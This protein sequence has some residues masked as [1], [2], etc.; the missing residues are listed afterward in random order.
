MLIHCE[1]VKQNIILGTEAK[2]L[3]NA[4]D[5]GAYVIAVDESSAARRWDEAWIN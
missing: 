4:L 5:V 3:A 1:H 2:T